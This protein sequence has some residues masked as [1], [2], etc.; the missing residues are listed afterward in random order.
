[1]TPEEYFKTYRIYLSDDVDGKMLKSFDEQLQDYLKH[2]ADQ[3]AAVTVVITSPGGN[4]VV[5]RALHERIRLLARLTDVNVLALGDC[6]SAAAIIYV[7]VA[8][9]QRYTTAHTHFLLHE[10]SRGAYEIQGGTVRE[11][12]MSVEKAAKAHEWMRADYEWMVKLLAGACGSDVEDM[13][14]IVETADHFNGA[15]A[16]SIGLAGSLLLDA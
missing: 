13:R 3:M 2:Q 7:A 14:R 9:G 11:R 6:S 1:M 16:I 15:Q 8:R 10:L 12:D 5:A 4:S